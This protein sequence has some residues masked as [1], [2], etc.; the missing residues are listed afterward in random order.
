MI[1]ELHI[2]GTEDTYRNYY[3][4]VRELND[5]VDKLDGAVSRQDSL[6]QFYIAQFNKHV[7]KNQSKIKVFKDKLSNEIIANKDSHP[8]KVI[9]YLNKVGYKLVPVYEQMT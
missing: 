6:R 9:S 1:K 8:A 2:Y 3:E 5:L 7:E 4:V